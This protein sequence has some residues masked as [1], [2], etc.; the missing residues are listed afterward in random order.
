MS[1]LLFNFFWVGSIRSLLKT[2][3]LSR[4]L[5]TLSNNQGGDVLGFGDLQS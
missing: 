3:F 4:N 5:M 2:A 1:L